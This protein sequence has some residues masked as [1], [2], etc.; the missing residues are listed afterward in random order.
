M[1]IKTTDIDFIPKVLRANIP[2]LVYFWAEQHKSCYTVT[3]IVEELTGEY[4][5]KLKVCKVNID[6]APY[7]SSEYDIKVIPAFLLFKSGKL[8]KKLINLS[9]KAEIETAIKHYI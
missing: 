9:A 3:P 7:V 2:V 6:E 1:A 4:K 5:D 8:V